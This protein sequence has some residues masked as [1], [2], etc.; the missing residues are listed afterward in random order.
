MRELCEEAFGNI[1]EEE[2]PFTM[3]GSLHG[4]QCCETTTNIQS[5]IISKEDR[6]ITK[7]DGQAEGELEA[8]SII[9]K[10]SGS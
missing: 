5:A 4:C 9:A 6:G 7:N 3:K 10:C 8:F 2:I 1:G